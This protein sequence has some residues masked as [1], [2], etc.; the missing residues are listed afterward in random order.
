MLKNY[1]NLSITQSKKWQVCSDANHKMEDPEIK[2]DIN[3]A[4]DKMALQEKCAK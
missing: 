3:E 2:E 1:N 4:L